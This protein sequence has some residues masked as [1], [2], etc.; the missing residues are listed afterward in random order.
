[1]ASPA[2]AGLP[3]EDR[4]LTASC[5]VSL[6]YHNDTARFARVP[7]SPVSGSNGQVPSR[8]GSVLSNHLASTGVWRPVYRI[9]TPIRCGPEMGSWSLNA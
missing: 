3:R 8:L 6:R 2:P 9:E 5:A 7:P 1:M 4:G